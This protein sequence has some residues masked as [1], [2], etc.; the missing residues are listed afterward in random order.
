MC[1]PSECLLVVVMVTM[2]MQGRVLTSA[3]AGVGGLLFIGQLKR[4]IPRAW[5]SSL[6]G[7]QTSMCKLSEC[8]LVDY[9]VIDDDDDDD[10][11]DN[12]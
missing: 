11:N 4:D 2:M 5:K 8:S 6:G 7:G 12:I 3:A 10:Y 9:C 1:K